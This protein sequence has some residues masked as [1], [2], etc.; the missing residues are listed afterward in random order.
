MKKIKIG[1][2]FLCAMFLFLSSIGAQA[3]E[4]PPDDELVSI[5]DSVSSNSGETIQLS[6][7]EFVRFLKYAMREKKNLFE[8]LNLVYPILIQNDQRYKIS[9]PVLIET[10][11]KYSLGGSKIRVIFPFES[12]KNMEIGATFNSQQNAFDVFID[13]PYS[14][15]FY[16]FGKLHEDEHFGFK[17]ISENYFN[18]AFGM[19]AK[20]MFFKFDVSHLHLY[21]SEEVA[22]H[23][24]NFFKPKREV[25]HAV[26]IH[27]NR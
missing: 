2:L 19:H 25:F 11:K 1:L 7:D 9:G 27:Q 3:V 8:L 18:E 21:E 15:D 26:E 6:K 10:E 4:Y 13:E 14:E 24:K 16:G 12:L 17:E 20:R 22:I 5:V 23:L